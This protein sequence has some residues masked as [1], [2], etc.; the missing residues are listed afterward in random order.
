MDY[1]IYVLD[2][3]TTG[4]DSRRFDV[5]ELSIF[6]LSDGVQKEWFIKPTNPDSYQIGALRVNGHK[7]ED[8]RHETVEGRTRYQNPNTVLVDIENWLMEDGL[9][10]HQRICIGQ[11]ITFDL[12]MLK[13]LWIKCD[14]EDNFPFGRRF[15]DTMIIEM[16]MDYCN[17]GMTK[18]YNLASIIKN[19]GVKN[20]KAHNAAADVRATKDVFLA[21]VA[22]FKKILNAASS[23]PSKE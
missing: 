15:M 22:K 2:T 12:D 8:L 4:L 5:I 7:I 6:R 3:E 23:G 18:K 11:N 13:Q 17:E 19:Y 16:F 14:S 9:P 1:S 21:Q 20:E 10:T